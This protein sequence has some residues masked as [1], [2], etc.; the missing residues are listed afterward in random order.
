MAA[1][2]VAAHLVVVA[3][4]AVAAG[5]VVVATTADWGPSIKYVTLQRGEGV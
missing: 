1:A 5:L 2:A 4:V 3:M